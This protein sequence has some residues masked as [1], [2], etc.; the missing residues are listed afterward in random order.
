MK[1]PSSRTPH[2]G[3]LEAADL[4]DGPILP[5][6]IHQPSQQAAMRKTT[7]PL[8]EQ[9]WIGFDT[10]YRN[11]SG[12]VSVAGLKQRGYVMGKAAALA[13][14]AEQDLPV[15]MVAATDESSCQA[16]YRLVTNSH[17]LGKTVGILLVATRW[18]V[19]PRQA[20]LQNAINLI[21]LLECP[22]ICA[23]T[24]RECGHRIYLLS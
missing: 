23:S 15:N 5:Q 10:D 4:S 3:P 8:I 9:A 11:A 17:R 18:Q 7:T 24:F 19:F 1:Q 20:I 6:D 22:V 2:Q 13:A 21:P 16:E 12:H 14:S